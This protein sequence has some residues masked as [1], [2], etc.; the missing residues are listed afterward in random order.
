MLADRSELMGC[1]GRQSSLSS[2]HTPVSISTG[3]RS[4]ETSQRMSSKFKNKLFVPARYHFGADN[5]HCAWERKRRSTS[6]KTEWSLLFS[7]LQL[8]PRM[9]K[10]KLNTWSPLMTR[11]QRF[12]TLHLWMPAAAKMEEQPSLPNVSIPCHDEQRDKKK[13]YTVRAQT[14]FRFSLSIVCFSC[15]TLSCLFQVYKVLV[16]V[17]QQEW[18]VFRRYA[19]FDKLY[20]TVS[21]GATAFSSLWFIPSL[22]WLIFVTFSP[23]LTFIN[24]YGNN[25]HLWT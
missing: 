22:I 23:P 12:V 8:W 17:G 3:R 10:R 19:E 5:D 14:W 15:V 4:Q 11:T 13:R 20:N 16:S 18:F 21:S 2:V 7:P 6:W 1:P 9:G 25:S 24:S